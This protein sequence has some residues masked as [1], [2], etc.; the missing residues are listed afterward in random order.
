MINVGFAMVNFG[1]LWY[2]LF[3]TRLHQINHWFTILYNWMWYYFSLFLLFS[4]PPL[5]FVITTSI[6]SIAHG[7]LLPVIKKYFWQDFLGI[8]GASVSEFLEKIVQKCCYYIHSANIYIAVS[9]PQSHYSV[10]YLSPKD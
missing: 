6:R 4:F 10:L 7:S 2:F 1:L 3:G 5:R 8:L 9:N